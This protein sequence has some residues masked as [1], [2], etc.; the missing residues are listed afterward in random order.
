MKTIKNFAIIV[1]IASFFLGCS[2]DDDPIVINEEEVITTIKATLVPQNGGTTVILE[3]KDLD[4]DGPNEPVVTVSGDFLQNTTYVGTLKVLNE[5]ES[6]S[7]DI[8]IEILEE[9]EEHQF[10]FLFTNSI[11]TA[12]YSDQDDNGN[13][14][15]VQFNMVT[16]NQGTG[17]F[18]ITLRHQP[19]KEGA[20]VITGD[21]TNAGGETD[22]QVTF[23]I[24][25]N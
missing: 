5:I 11:A 21:I 6:P 9:D 16:T 8:T 23:N 3:S 18:T 4:G 24:S 12:S 13:P 14:I 15:G 1:F 7:E 17:D 10:F 22:I 19:N 2:N 25:V 20:N